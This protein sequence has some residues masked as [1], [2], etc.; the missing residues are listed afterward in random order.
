MSEGEKMGVP[1]V[2]GADNLPVGIELTDLPGSGITVDYTESEF[3]NQRS[4]FL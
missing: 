2:I 4:I 3:W 1:V